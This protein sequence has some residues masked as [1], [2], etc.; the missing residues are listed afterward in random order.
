M[1]HKAVNNLYDNVVNQVGDRAYDINGDLVDVDEAKVAKEI[2]KIEAD[3][4]SKQYQR[5]R[6]QEYP[7]LQEC[8]HALLDGGNT[9]T[10]LQSK[11][12]EIKKKYPKET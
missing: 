9:L 10:E 2:K 4:K 6:L 12:S 5:D 11:R 1:R 7:D 3:F 8:I